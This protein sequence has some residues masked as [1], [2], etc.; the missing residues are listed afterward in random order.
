MNK[1]MRLFF[2]LLNW[3]Q[4]VVFEMSTVSYIPSL[5]DTVLEH[6]YIRII[7]VSYSNTNV[8]EWYICTHTYKQHIN[9]TA[10]YEHTTN[11][12]RGYQR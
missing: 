7:H 2:V 11:R 4:F 12:S 8:R 10:N 3:I 1:A 9:D 5:V 6:T